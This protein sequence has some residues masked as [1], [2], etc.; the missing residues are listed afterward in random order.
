MRPTLPVFSRC[1][2]HHRCAGMNRGTINNIDP[3]TFFEIA[4]AD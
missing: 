2:R 3:P 4:L 1:P